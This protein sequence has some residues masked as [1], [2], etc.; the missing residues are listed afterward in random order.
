[1]ASIRERVRG[2][3][4][5]YTVQFRHEGKQRGPTFAT[6]AK[7]EQ[8]V[9]L[10][11]AGGTAR[12]V[13]EIERQNATRARAKV[14]PT[15]AQML[16]KHTRTLTGITEGTRGTYEM[17]TRQFADSPL[18][19]LA[20]DIVSRDDVVAWVREQ[21]KSGASAKTIKNKQTFLSTAFKRAVL[22]GE[23]TRNPAE[24]VRITRTERREM[25]FLTPVEFQVLLERVT[26]YYRPFVAFLYGTG[27]RFGEAIALRVQDVH[28]DDAPP[29][30][31]VAR[32]WKM[33]GGYGPPKTSRGRRTIS[34][35]TY[36][37]D[38]VRTASKGKAPGE[39]VFTNKRGERIDRH[40]M[41]G[42]W[43]TWIDE[44]RAAKRGEP[45]LGKRPRLHDI[46]HS[47]ASWMLAQ[48]YDLH[49]LARR[50]GHES[51]QTTSDTYG[52]LLP[53]AQ[54]QAVRAANL[55]L[56]PVP[57]PAALEPAPCQHDDATGKP[58]CPDCGTRL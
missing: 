39:L 54:I 45:L 5:T 8:L 25:T 43:L 1:M 22:D 41:Y 7:A 24:A 6:R 17:M 47:H 16:A 52:H 3:V 34:L 11:E 58:F 48:G 21:E 36:A 38:A 33:G 29:T 50:L 32:A 12:A 14:K 13:Q 55:A 35:P 9:A 26:V 23:I 37:V 18:G 42:N 31:T 28:L 20:V 49:S 15:V 56:A 27:M 10:I 4:T 53:E 51:I 30:V 40:T 2:D 46:R 44:E 57:S 19:G